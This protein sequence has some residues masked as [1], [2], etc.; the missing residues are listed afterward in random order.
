MKAFTEYLAELNRKYEFVVRVANCSTEG[1]LSENIKGALAQYKVESVGSARRLPIQE[2]QE[3]PGLGPCEVH[4]VEVTVVYPTITDQI[5]QLIAER[6]HISAKNVIVR[7]KLE[8]SQREAK[9]IEPRK[10]KDGSI[11]SN[12]DMETESAHH[13]VGNQ[14][15]DSMLKELQSRKYE[16]AAKGETAPAVNMPVNTKSPVGSSQNK[17]PSPKGK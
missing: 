3:F 2:H 17:I 5:R 6:L 9:P 10:A 14:R 15:V 13:L 12:P 8:E 4:L 16:F 7:T 11:I 1:S